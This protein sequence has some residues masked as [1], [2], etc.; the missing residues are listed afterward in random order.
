MPFPP[1]DLKISSQELSASELESKE[2][3][4]RET[5]TE[6]L[7]RRQKA[8]IDSRKVEIFK[9]RSSRKRYERRYRGAKK[10]VAGLE[11][12]FGKVFRAHEEALEKREKRVRAM[13]DELART[14]E[15]LAARSTE[16]SAMQSFLSTADRITEE[17]VLSIVRD[18]NKQV[19][20]VATNLTREW[21]KLGP[22]SSGKFFITKKEFEEFSQF[23]GPVL[24]NQSLK[25]DP[26]T[27]K[28][29]V[30]SCF[31]FVA[32]QITSSWRHYHG[33]E[34]GVLGSVYK[35]LTTSGMCT[36]RTISEIRLMHARGT[37][38]LS[39]MEVPDS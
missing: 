17:E 11:H 18:L 20:R 30:Q 36:S 13:E 32:T 5:S 9:L 34:L 12:E 31:C 8:K 28:F 21:E 27:V 29:L 23:Y 4:I 14:K 24:V 15:L 35:H 22:P 2:L 26:A 1:E 10:E 16:L 19:R 7:A 39:Y 33:V 6:D 38:D 3:R 25:G 37:A